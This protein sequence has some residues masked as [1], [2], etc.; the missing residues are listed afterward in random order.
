MAGYSKQQ[1]LDNNIMETMSKLI[2]TNELRLSSWRASLIFRR[3]SPSFADALY[4]SISVRLSLSGTVTL[5]FELTLTKGH[6]LSRHLAFVVFRWARFS[7]YLSL[8]VEA[9]AVH[10]GT[11]HGNRARAW[12]DTEHAQIGQRGLGMIRTLRIH[13]SLQRSL[14]NNNS[15]TE[16]ERRTTYDEQ[17]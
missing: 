7:I 11:I 15:A 14:E 4:A 6:E 10:W 12:W 9:V 1:L 13:C 3:A 2:H 16:Q 5:T 8:R 17:L